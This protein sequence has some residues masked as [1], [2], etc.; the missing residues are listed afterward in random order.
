MLESFTGMLILF[1]GRQLYIIDFGMAKEITTSLIYKLGT[2]TPNLS[3]MTLGLVLKL[4][5]LGSKES[6][7]S[8]LSKFLSEEQRSQFSL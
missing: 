8:Y 2:S 4:K 7:Y 1:K 5:E 3:I 6:S